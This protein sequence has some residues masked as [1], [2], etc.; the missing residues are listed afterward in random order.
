MPVGLSPEESEWIERKA[1]HVGGIDAALRFLVRQGLMAFLVI[2]DKERHA[3]TSSAGDAYAR[4][5]RQAARP[6]PGHEPPP[7]ARDSE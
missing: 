1:G 4:E 2:E 3:G 6:A 5:L 7:D